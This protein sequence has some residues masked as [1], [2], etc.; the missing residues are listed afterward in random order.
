[1][2]SDVSHNWLPAQLRLAAE[3]CPISRGPAP[4]NP[5]PAPPHKGMSTGEALPANF[6]NRNS[7][8]AA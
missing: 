2:I 5:D 8:T 6:Q 4:A 3:I 7:G 1:M